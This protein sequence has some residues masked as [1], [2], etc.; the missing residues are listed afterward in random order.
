[1]GQFLKFCLH[2]QLFAFKEFCM[3]TRL[4][5][6]IKTTNLTKLTKVILESSYRVVKVISK[7]KTLKETV[8]FLKAVEVCRTSD[9]QI[10]YILGKVA[11]LHFLETPQTSLKTCQHSFQ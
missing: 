5:N 6:I 9:I 10:G 4:F 11:K 1:M 2:Q 8:Y 7:W 3:E